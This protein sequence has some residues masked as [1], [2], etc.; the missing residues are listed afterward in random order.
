MA[1]QSIDP[2]LFMTLHEAVRPYRLRDCTM[3]NA[4]IAEHLG[5]QHFLEDHNGAPNCCFW[6][7]GALVAIRT[8]H[9]EV[10]IFHVWQR[11]QTKMER[12]ANRILEQPPGPRI[13]D[14]GYIG[15]DQ[16]LEVW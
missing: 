1:P 10:S 12:I 5:L 7:S 15:A 14:A 8:K 3:T 16:V 13:T 2:A 11:F 9:D 4:Q 6:Q